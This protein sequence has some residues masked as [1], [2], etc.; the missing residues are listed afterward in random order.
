MSAERIPTTIVSGGLGAGKTTLLNHLL[1]NAEGRDLAVVVNDMGELNVDERLVERHVDLGGS[2][3]LG[4]ENGCICCGL[5]GDLRDELFALARSCEFE[6]LVIEASGISEPAPVAGLF[7]GRGPI[8]DRYELDTTVT[9]VDAPRFAA[10][11]GPEVPER[12]GPS[13]DGTRPL[14]DLA[15]EQVEFCDVLVANKRD[16][17][18]DEE[19][20][21][22]ERLLRALQPDAE[23]L[24]SSFGDVAPETI[25]G[26]GRFDPERART[27]AGWKRALDAHGH[28]GHEHDADHDHDHLHPPEEYGVGSVVVEAHRPAHPKRFVDWLRDPPA[29]LVRV[30]G[31]VWVAGR[32]ED[33]LV[34]GWAGN[35][36][37]VSVSG[38]W[39]ASLPER[40]RER[41][42]EPDVQWDEQWGD[43]AIQLV[44]L[45]VG[46]DEAAV[47]ESVED[48]LLTDAEMEGDWSRF[49]NP[50][51]A[52]PD[53][54][55]VLERGEPIRT[56]PS[57][58]QS[59]R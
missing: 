35:H 21:S 23:L 19:V 31:I 56:V 28:A 58:R 27:A 32:E 39:V 55:L 7:V 9:V 41:Y 17:L 49:E 29:D 37:R 2:E 51:P 50:F 26:A 13:E 18:S 34:V 22:V 25:L 33:A 4:L 43:R 3:L 42:R 20:E 30:K 45:G 59:A 12:Q 46:I 8:G 53:T 11:F 52:R 10:T 47:R 36:A 48:C 38:R 24:W 5:Q 44:C 40:G 1:S 15:V 14:S 16:L 57:S 54:E 6:Q